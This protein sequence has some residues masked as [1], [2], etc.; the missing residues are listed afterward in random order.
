MTEQINPVPSRSRRWRLVDA[1]IGIVALGLIAAG[2]I[3]LGGTDRGL[4]D[5][6]V[7]LE[8]APVTVYSPLDA[9]QAPVAVIAH[10]FAG[11]RQMMQPFATTLAR[12]GYVAVSFD[13]PGHGS[14]PLPLEG[15]LGEPER[16]DALLE[17]V[18]Q[19]VDYATTLPQFDGRLALVG[20]SMA[21][22]IAARY[23]QTSN[24]SAEDAEVADTPG[25]DA[26]SARPVTRVDALV[27]LSPYLSQDIGDHE[28]DATPNNMLFVYGELEPEVVQAQGRNAVAAVAGLPADEIAADVTYGEHGDGSARRLV[29]ADRVEHIGVLYSAQTLEATLQWLNKVFGHQGNGWIDA[30]GPWLAI[31]FLG[32]IL[33][34][35]PLARLLPRVSSKPLGANLEWRRLLPAALLPAL[36][37]PLIL[38]PFP[39]DFLPIAIA[40][41]VA[42]HFA[43]YALLTGVALL[44]LGGFVPT[45]GRRTSIGAFLVA[46]ITVIL[47]QTVTIAIPTDRYVA[48]FL[49]D[50]HR[51][52]ILLVLLAATTAWFTTDEWLTRGANAVPG[53]YPL[54]K[55]LFLLSLLLAVALNLRDL[56]FLVIIV[57]A[58]LILFIVFGLFSRW[59]YR[60]TGH[61]LVAALANALAFAVAITASFPI[62]G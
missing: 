35:W 57:P 8:Q 23:A 28:P 24:P 29:V 17:A 48:A 47:Y 54:T 40:D 15:K 9:E 41:Y 45:D 61:P 30:R 10:G 43:V 14:N 3:W 56:F 7:A 32:V 52:G 44:L 4:I 50:P 60:R 51:W 38:R 37:T 20:H 42:L 55:A 36:L 21:G 53:A 49:P 13:F 27:A 25:A 16:T 18:S 22:D 39:S 1:M 5:S 46:L 33:L 59:V 19:V 12:N 26:H 62:T 31:Y 2:L 11:S 6:E 34:A 58:V